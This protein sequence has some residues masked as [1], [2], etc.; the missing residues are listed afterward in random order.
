MGLHC[1]LLT[2]TATDSNIRTV[3]SGICVVIAWTL[4]ES[5]FLPITAKVFCKSWS[6]TVPIWPISR[7]RICGT[8]NEGE[9]H[10]IKGGGGAHVLHINSNSWHQWIVHYKVNSLFELA[11]SSSGQSFISLETTLLQATYTNT[12]I[13]S[14]KIPPI[15]LLC[16]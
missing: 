12:N 2:Y 1:S 13:S 7:A 9:I 3:W 8:S 14:F 15:K 10:L 11:V 5:K 6:S 4:R 16:H